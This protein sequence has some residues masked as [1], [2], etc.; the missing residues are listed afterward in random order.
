MIPRHD[1]PLVAAIVLIEIWPLRDPSWKN[2]SG[3]EVVDKRDHESAEHGSPVHRN[4]FPDSPRVDPEAGDIEKDEDAKQRC[5]PADLDMLARVYRIEKAAGDRRHRQAEQQPV[6]RKIEIEGAQEPDSLVLPFTM[7]IF[8]S[9]L[10]A[11]I[12][13]LPSPCF[14]AFQHFS[15]SVFSFS[16]FSFS[17]F[18]FF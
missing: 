7:S 9:L 12:S 18:S 16:V 11:P 6:E 10:P 4:P 13:H 3:C 5:Q 15:F 1:E 2:Q 17:V 14:P 8:P